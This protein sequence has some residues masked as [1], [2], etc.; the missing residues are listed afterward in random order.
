MLYGITRA[1]KTGASVSHGGNGSGTHGGSKKGKSSLLYGLSLQLLVL[2]VEMLLPHCEVSW[3]II[4]TTYAPRHQSQM[5]VSHPK[6]E[7]TC[8][9][10]QM[11]PHANPLV[12]GN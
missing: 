5:M 6:D 10:T 12:I 9:P 4:L 3:S 8:A 1:F 2:V 11:I 7:H